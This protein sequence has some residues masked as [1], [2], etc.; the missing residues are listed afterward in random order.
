MDYFLAS[1]P[2]LLTTEGESSQDQTEKRELV[3]LP[4]N[5][6]TD[7]LQ[8]V[9]KIKVAALDYRDEGKKKFFSDEVNSYL[10]R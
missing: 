2:P 3:K 6:S 9:H 5:I 4:E 7:I 1:E 10:L 8:I